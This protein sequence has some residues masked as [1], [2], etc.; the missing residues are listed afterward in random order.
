[1]SE[2]NA[3]KKRTRKERGTRWKNRRWANRSSFSRSGGSYRSRQTI[4]PVATIK[5]SSVASVVSVLDRNFRTKSTRKT[6]GKGTK[7]E[8]EIT[9]LKR[10]SP[11]AR[12]TLTT[13]QVLIAV[14]AA[15][16]F[17]ETTPGTSVIKTFANTRRHRVGT[18]R[19]ENS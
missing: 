10:Q 18:D 5:G 2:Q 6:G 16:S 13:S 7:K 14:A 4:A 3:S 17:L 8:T 1:M 15:S 9:R 11:G 19:R 12:D